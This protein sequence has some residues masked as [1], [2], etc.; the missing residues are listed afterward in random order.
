MDKK[1]LMEQLDEMKSQLEKSV[2]EKTKSE[3]KSEIKALEDKINAIDTKSIAEGVNEVKDSVKTI[4]DWQVKKDEADK[5]NQEALDNL[6]ANQK[7]ASPKT[8]TKTFSQN[9]AEAVEEK[10]DE[11]SRVSKGRKAVIELK[12]AGNMSVSANLTGDGTQSYGGQVILPGQSIN[13]R[14]ILP[15]TLSPNRTY[16]QHREK[17]T[18][19]GAVAAQTEGSAKAQL[20]IDFEKIETVNQYVAGFARFTKQLAKE[21]SF[22]QNTLPR[23]LLR[24]FYE[25]ENSKFFT[26]ITGTSGISTSV[27]SETDDI[28]MLI[29]A[30]AYQLNSN[31]NP[32]YCLV[33]P[34]QLARLN[35]SLYD[36][37]NYASAAG[38]VSSANGQLSIAG[39]PIISASWVT[40][41]KGLI[42]DQTFV[43][44]VEVEGLTIEF[45]E[46]DS[47]NVQKNMITA[48]IE[49]FEAVNLM[50]PASARYWDF[51]NES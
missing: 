46:Q 25:A 9:F 2:S 29:D 50:L 21:L 11:I 44:R 39:V 18:G 32:S 7:K 45:F 26:D 10:W 4:T 48:R 14:D 24:K 23:I 35:K 3:L 1:E 47:D 38:V 40:D 20:D 42:I 13:F 5:K 33:N 22:F 31:Y 16:A 28:K 34:L 51:G 8:E 37:Q 17:T 27:G 43:E 36:S 12:A 15:T 19:E 6:I 49:C 41:D 30:I